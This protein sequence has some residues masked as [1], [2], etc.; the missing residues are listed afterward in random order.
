MLEACLAKGL[1]LL[2]AGPKTLRFVPPY[3]ISEEEITE[4]LEILKSVLD[5]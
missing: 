1:L 2:S 3:I 4:G 5:A